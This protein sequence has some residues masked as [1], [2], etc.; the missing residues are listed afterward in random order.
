[1][2]KSVFKIGDVVYH[3]EF[4]QGTVKDVD[5]IS[6]QQPTY[7]CFENGTFW[8]ADEALSF[9]PWPAPD[10]KRPIQEGWWI[11]ELGGIPAI[12][13]KRKGASILF[14]ADGSIGSSLNQ[15]EFIR[16]L[17]KDWRTAE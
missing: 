10:H 13:E 7:A 17:G 15:Y 9:S 2:S 1:M 14:G 12:R 4:G 5:K 11:V 16:Y 3:P 6:P 8:F